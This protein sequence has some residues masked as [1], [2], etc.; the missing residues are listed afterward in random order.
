MI[1]VKVFANIISYFGTFGAVSNQLLRY[2]SGFN[3]RTEQ[4]DIF[5]AYRYYFQSGCLCMCVICLF[6]PTTRDVFL[7]WNDDFLKEEYW[8]FASVA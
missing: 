1:L 2:G 5:M 8:S 3:F 7:L 4:I 6:A